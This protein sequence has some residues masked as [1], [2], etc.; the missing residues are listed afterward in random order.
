MA[1]TIGAISVRN[2]QTANAVRISAA[3]AT[4]ALVVRFHG[5]EL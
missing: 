3:D 5:G 2:F 4:I 1:V